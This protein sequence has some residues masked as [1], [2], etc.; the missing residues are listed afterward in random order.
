MSLQR[1]LL[2][3]LSGAE[4]GAALGLD[5]GRELHVG[6]GD[7]FRDRLSEGTLYKRIAKRMN[8]LDQELA[9]AQDQLAKHEAATPPT[10]PWI[11]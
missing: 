11:R 8:E 1:T 4:L 5:L 9:H 10:P 6:V 3:P 2:C 7:A